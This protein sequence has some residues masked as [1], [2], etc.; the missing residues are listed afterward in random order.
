MLGQALQA[1]KRMSFFAEKLAEFGLSIKGLHH[2]PGGLL[3]SPSLLEHLSRFG[4]TVLRSE[5]NGLQPNCEG[6]GLARVSRIR[7]CAQRMDSLPNA[8][9]IHPG[10]GQTAFHQGKKRTGRLADGLRFQNGLAESRCPKVEVTADDELARF[11]CKSPM[12]LSVLREFS[13]N[14][15]GFF[16]GLNGA[17]WVRGIRNQVCIQ[18]LCISEFVELAHVAQ[19]CCCL[20]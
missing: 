9:H 15:S 11:V 4:E 13:V 10:L 19:Q 1:L 12:Q 6:L 14:C 3:K 18:V 5:C 7:F 16:K 8:V 20:V 2:M 17:A